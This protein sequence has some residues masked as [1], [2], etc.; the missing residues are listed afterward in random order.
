MTMISV[1]RLPQT[2]MNAAPRTA[3]TIMTMAVANAM[4]VVDDDDDSTK[5]PIVVRIDT[6]KASVLLTIIRVV[7]VAL[8]PFRVPGRRSIELAIGP[9]WIRLPVDRLVNPHFYMM[10]TWLSRQYTVYGAWVGS[11]HQ[12]SVSKQCG[13]HLTIN[14][15]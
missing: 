11:T 12:R 9:P 5:T 10:P 1:H 4:I 3:T 2:T 7:A 8:R 13:C 14:I 6:R 15:Y